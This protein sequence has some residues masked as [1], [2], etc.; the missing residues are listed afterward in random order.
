MA[1]RYVAGPKA[2]RTTRGGTSDI[3]ML[4]CGAGELLVIEER[5]GR[6]ELLF[7][8]RGFVLWTEREGFAV[9]D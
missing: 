3:F 7:R 8:V 4:T 9:W 2:L 1:R 6:V 5:L